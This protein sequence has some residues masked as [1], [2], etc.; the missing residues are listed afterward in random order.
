MGRK[1]YYE[2]TTDGS[3]ITTRVRAYSLESQKGEPC[4]CLDGCCTKR[5]LF[6]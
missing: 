4:E 3:R 5:N 1:Q 2:K 6:N